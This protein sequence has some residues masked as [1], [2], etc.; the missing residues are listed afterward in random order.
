MRERKE[1]N[2]E[3]GRRVRRARD[4]TDTQALRELYVLLRSALDFGNPEV[5]L[6]PCF[7]GTPAERR[8]N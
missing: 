4:D 1:I 8:W 6:Y 5:W 3:V 7:A 2:I